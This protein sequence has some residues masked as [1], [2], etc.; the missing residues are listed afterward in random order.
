[1]F[2]VGAVVYVDQ[3][4]NGDENKMKKSKLF[5]FRTI[6]IIL[7]ILVLKLS[8]FKSYYYK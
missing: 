8:D 3:V 7:L 2:G 6:K 5:V 1:M 4:T